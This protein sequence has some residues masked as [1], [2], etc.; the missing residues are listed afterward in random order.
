MNVGEWEGVLLRM[1]FLWLK[2]KIL[3][4]SHLHGKASQEVDHVI[5]P[6]LCDIPQV[7]DEGLGSPE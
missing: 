1:K 3:E 7:E 2:H 6:G 4:I 5:S